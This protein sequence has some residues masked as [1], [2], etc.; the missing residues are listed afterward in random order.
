MCKLEEMQVFRSPAY[1]SGHQASITGYA[2]D[3]TCEFGVG[4]RPVS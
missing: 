1:N 3:S 4:L 2:T